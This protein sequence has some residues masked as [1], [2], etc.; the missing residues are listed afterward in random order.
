MAVAVLAVAASA[1]QA[2]IFVDAALGNDGSFDPTDP[3]TPYAT[4]S[5][6]VEDANSNLTTAYIIKVV[7]GDYTQA[8]ETT[9]AGGGYPMAIVNPST[10]MEGA[11]ADPEDFPRIGGDVDDSDVRALFDV[12]ATST[13]GDLTD[14]RFENLHFVGEDSENEDAPGALY[15]ENVDN[16]VAKV[17]LVYCRIDRSVMNASGSDGRPS[18]LMV[19]G[20]VSERE[21]GDLGVELIV[22]GCVIEPT[23]R[24]GIELAVSND[25]ALP[26]GANVKLTA[27]NNTFEL[28]GSEAADFAIEFVIK[29]Q[30][31]ETA[32]GGEAESLIVGNIVDSSQSYSGFGFDRG[33]VMGGQVRNGGSAIMNPSAQVVEGN[34]IRGTS[35]AALTFLA[36]QDDHEASQ[37]NIQ[38]WRADRNTVAQNRAFGVVLDWGG[39]DDLEYLR[40]HLRGNMIVDNE[41]SGVLLAGGETSQGGLTSVG[42]TIAGN[43]GY[44]IENYAGSLQAMA[45]TLLWGNAL[46]SGYGW[47]F[48]DWQTF[49]HND[50][51]GF[52][53][54]VDE[55]CTPDPGGN[56]DADPDFVNAA[57]GD[58]HLAGT[59]CLLNRGAFSPEG[60]GASPTLL[61][62]DGETRFYGRPDIGADEHR[63]EE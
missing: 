54:T 63:P 59:S 13:T 45:N 10:R 25:A 30:D 32:I 48:S 36:S 29:A 5:R 14:I 39:G 3:E 7:E 4:I 35:V 19:G 43:G 15:V 46:G 57:G 22:V 56:L 38:V 42:D 44:G 2:T 21:V 61:D 49:V 9:F 18:I 8:H 24:G 37:A 16:A 55:T 33:I 31:G 50:V 60:V 52:R 62:I 40:I 11:S 58:Y 6:A 47:E 12:I 28:S 1:M 34:Q 20:D 53:P 27:I 26:D 51:R 41:D 23:S 17:T